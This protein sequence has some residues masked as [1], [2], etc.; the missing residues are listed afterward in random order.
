MLIEIAH[1]DLWYVVTTNSIEYVKVRFGVRTTN[2]VFVLQT[3]D[4]EGCPAQSPD[5]QFLLVRCVATPTNS[6]QI[7]C[8][9]R[10]IVSRLGLSILL[11]SGCG[12]V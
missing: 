10:Q 8:V 12:F 7:G 11:W 6:D 9:Y 2:L 3:A 4:E 5:V 1:I